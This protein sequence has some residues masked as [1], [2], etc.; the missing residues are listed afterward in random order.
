MDKYNVIYVDFI[1]YTNSV[2]DQLTKGLNRA[3]IPKHRKK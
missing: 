3:T 1:K 2:I